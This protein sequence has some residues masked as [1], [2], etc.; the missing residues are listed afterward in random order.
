[1]NIYTAT[2]W[3]RRQ[4]MRR[5]N[6]SIRTLGHTITHDWTVWEEQNPSKDV[7]SRRHGAAMLDYAGVHACDLLIFWDHPEAN[8]ARWEAGGAAWLGKPVWIVEYQNIVVFDALPHVTTFVT[9]AQ[10]FD[11]LDPQVALV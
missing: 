7:E 4:E 2:K 3:E 10:V 5:H 6:N 8:G 1:M 9:W 11:A